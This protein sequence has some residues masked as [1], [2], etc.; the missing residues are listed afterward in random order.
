MGREYKS[1]NALE[2]RLMRTRKA[3]LVREVDKGWIESLRFEDLDSSILS[4][5]PPGRLKT[6]EFLLSKLRQEFQ[7]FYLTNRTKNKKQK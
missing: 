1:Q 3:G 6:G 7:H 2:V 5:R 4:A